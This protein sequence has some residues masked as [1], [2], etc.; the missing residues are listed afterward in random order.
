MDPA[1]AGFFLCASYYK[2]CRAS[3][4]YRREKGLND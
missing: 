1:E 4:S 2:K 3:R